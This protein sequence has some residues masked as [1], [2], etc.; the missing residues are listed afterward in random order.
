MNR[1]PEAASH[2]FAF[3]RNGQQ[4]KRSPETPFILQVIVLPEKK[5]K[6]KVERVLAPPSSRAVLALR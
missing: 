4:N 2:G 3:K 6:G 5:T 1:Q